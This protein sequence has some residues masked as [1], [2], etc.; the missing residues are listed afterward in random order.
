MT[1]RP[2]IASLFMAVLLVIYLGFT[3]NYAWIL[4]RDP[5][6]LVQAMGY[7]LVVLPLLGA[8]GLTTELLFARRASKLTE[9]LNAKGM[10]P[11]LGVT[12]MANESLRRDAALKE[13]D[14]FRSET[15][16]NP[17]S[18]ESWLRLGLVYYQCGDKRRAR[19]AV[20]RAIS[21]ERGA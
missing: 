12:A 10:S 11:D 9:R 1:D 19:S 20:R 17:Q 7:A 13:F 6:L 18:W 8:W 21:L 2:K 15:Q 5:S 16:N 4:V 3:I 14:R